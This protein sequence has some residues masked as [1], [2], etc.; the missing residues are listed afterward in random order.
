MVFLYICKVTVYKIILNIKMRKCILWAFGMATMLVSCHKE[1]RYVEIISSTM[2][3]PWQRVLD[4]EVPKFDLDL[5]MGV[6]DS[7][8]V[9]DPLAFQQTIEGFG[10]CFN[11]LG[12]TSLSVLSQSD[13]DSIFRELYAPGVGANF[14]MNRMPLGSNDFS[15]DYYSYDDMDGDFD[16]AHFSIE[17]DEA[18][19]LPFIRAAKAQNP[20]LRI[21]ASPWCP[22][23]WMK[24]NKHYACVS[25][26][27]LRG[28]FDAENGLSIDKQIHEGEDGFTQDP[29]YLETYARYFGKFID[30]YKE[31]GVDVY[32]VM[33]QNEPNSAQWYP[34]CTWTPQGLNAFM[35]Y[36]GPEMEKR[37]VKMFLGTMERADASM[38]DVILSDAETAPYIKGMGFQWAGKDAIPSLHQKYSD[39]PVYQSEQECGNGR[40]DL[41]GAFHSWDLMKYYLN[42]GTNAYFYWNISLLEGGVSHWGWRQN[43]LVTV[44]EAEKTFSFTPEYYVMKH[45]SHYV[46]PGAK[47]LKLGGD[48]KNALAFLNTNGSLVVVLG[49]Q[50]DHPYTLNLQFGEHTYEIHLAAQSLST[51]NIR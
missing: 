27:M 5:T 25:T 44:N 43:S 22:P 45:V 14:T 50:T 23:A 26:E 41:A 4:M 35:K 3:H 13:R 51:L 36:L 18:T 39:L 30:A 6:G 11:E 42:N 37:G 17:H 15:L 33:P 24:T 21:W 1:T 16:L 40:N 2:E 47:V 34:A 32:M 28:R 19:L 46:L 31:K 38:W 20:D 29:K 48:C 9:I 12:W 8:L 10:A 7:T 49:N